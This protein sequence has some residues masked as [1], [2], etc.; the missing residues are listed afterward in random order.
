MDIWYL[1]LRIVHVVGAAFW[2][3]AGLALVGYVEPAAGEAGPEGQRLMGRLVR[4]GL[5]VAMN[6]AAVL[7]VLAGIALYWRASGG[8]QSA[9]WMQTSA[10]TAF[11]VG[12]VVGLLAVV[13][14]GAVTGPTAAAIG[15]LGAA[16]QAQGGPP[17]PEQQTRLA[18]LQ[19]RYRMS[20]RVNVAL[21]ALA[22]LLMA[23]AR[24]L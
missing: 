11:G 1:A 21:V 19:G 18:A 9:E 2:F 13:L 12:G 10:G 23:S 24:A 4:R 8:F 17:T 5:P 14:G 3:G 6:S 22:M 15:K 16:I 20:A 7:T